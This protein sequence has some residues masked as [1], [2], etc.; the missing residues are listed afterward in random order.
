MAFFPAASAFPEVARVVRNLSQVP[1][2]AKKYKAFKDFGQFSDTEARQVLGLGPDPRISIED[3]GAGTFGRYRSGDTIIL[4]EVIAMQFERLMMSWGWSRGQSIGAGADLARWQRLV[5]QAARIVESTL[6]HEMVHW[7]DAR[8]DGATSDAE[9]I[10]LGWKD[11]GHMFVSRAYGP[12]FKYLKEQLRGGIVVKAPDL[13]VD[14][15]I[16]WDERRR[17]HDPLRYA[18]NT[19]GPPQPP[20]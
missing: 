10:R 4:S 5:A 6:L 3:L 11:V 2:D 1:G 8:A 20:R 14:G 18:T 17:P 12:R 15:W 19:S 9:A 13:E 7:G 16:G